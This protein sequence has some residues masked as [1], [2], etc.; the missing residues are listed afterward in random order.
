MSAE[1]EYIANPK[2]CPHKWQPISM[3]F[4]TQ[5]L[6]PQGRVMVRQPDADKAKVYM[7]CLGCAQH[8]YMETSWANYRLYGSGD[9]DNEYITGLESISREYDP[10]TQ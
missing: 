5:L 10:A 4:E 8:T 9:R 6:D 3:V 7:V 2:K 1:A